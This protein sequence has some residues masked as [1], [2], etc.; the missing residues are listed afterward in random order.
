M[1]MRRVHIPVAGMFLFLLVSC[2][3]SS[4]S[5][6]PPPAVPPPDPAALPVTAANAQDITVDVLEAITSSIEIVDFV[7]II[8]LPVVSGPPPGLSKPPLRDIFIEIVACDTGQMTATWNDLDDNLDISTGDTF[9]IVFEMC[10]SA[11]S[12]I[13]L[14]GTTS[15][16]EMVIIGDPF[17]QITPWGL[18]MTFGYDNLSATDPF[19]TVILD[20]ALVLDMGSADNVTVNMS[21][22]ATALTAQQSGESETLSDYLLAQTLDLNAL[23]QTINAAGTLTSTVLDGSVTF[24]TIVDFVVMADDNPSAG[25]ML[26]AHASSSVLVT[27]LDNINVQL[28]VDLDLNGTIDETIVVTWAELDID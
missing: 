16:T 1:T 20:G 8:D 25:Q 13:T 5:G 10:F 2:G 24:E 12:G 3:G 7:D 19:G 6:T 18:V 14:D 23:L 26:I 27:V 15:F 22:A 21:I 11:G 4:S 17:G 28:D 9:D